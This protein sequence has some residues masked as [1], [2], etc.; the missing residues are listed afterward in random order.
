M[1]AGGAFVRGLCPVCR[2]GKI[3][4]GRTMSEHC[5]VCGLRFERESGY[6]ISAMYISYAISLPV[7][8]AVFAVFWW[9]A[10]VE[11]G[12]ALFYAGLVFL[13]FVPLVVRLSRVA[14]LHL[15]HRLDPRK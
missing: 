2:A 11:Y 4:S 3:Y 15:D 14:W 9:Y 5:P 8:L 6:F 12:W 7:V 13:P 10:D 1:T